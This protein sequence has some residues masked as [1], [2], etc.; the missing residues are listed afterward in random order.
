MCISWINKKVFWSNIDVQIGNVALQIEMLMYKVW[1]Q[2]GHAVQLWDEVIMDL[3][4]AILLFRDVTPC[5]FTNM[6]RS[7]R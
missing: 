1:L 5:G 3:K 2:D 6:Y 4:A 7:L